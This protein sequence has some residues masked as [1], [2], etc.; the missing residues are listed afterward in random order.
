M[1]KINVLELLENGSKIHIK[2][3]N[4]GKFIKNTNK[5]LIPK[6]QVGKKLLKFFESFG[7]A[8]IAGESGVGTSMAIASGYQY[9]P[10]TRKWEQSEENLKEAKGL[11]N[12]LAVLSTFSPTYYEDILFNTAV[13]GI[14]K[15]RQYYKLKKAFTP[16]KNISING[17]QLTKSQINA[18]EQSKQQ[19]INNKTNNPT[20]AQIINNSDLGFIVPENFYS[21]VN[22]AQSEIK[23]FNGNIW[24]SNDPDVYTYFSNRN[25][26]GSNNITNRFQAGYPKKAKIKE[27]D[28][29]N[30]DFRSNLDS[31]EV[32]RDAVE[33]G[34]DV[35]K[36]N[37]IIELTNPGTNII[38]P[39]GTDRLIIS[40]KPKF[41][42]L[43]LD[44]LKF[45]Y[46][47]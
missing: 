12:N 35:I 2:E 45:N 21:G 39:K 5:K 6:A 47:K 42:Y 15:A 44:W 27:V 46:L 11:R 25:Y 18:L 38:I 30:N 19:L 1:E 13:K 34:F 3:K 36:Q 4:K 33:N 24:L 29:K 31:D 37:N 26:K 16:Y 40:K 20:I 28:F 23:G 8:Q 17:Q 22:A 9:N 32:V 14:N 41:K 43:D 10:K 7:N